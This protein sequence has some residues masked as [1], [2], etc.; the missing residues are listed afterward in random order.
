MA[1]EVPVITTSPVDCCIGNIPVLKS[2]IDF[3]VDFVTINL[4]KPLYCHAK[5]N[6]AT[7]VECIEY[8]SVFETF[9]LPVNGRYIF[10]QT[11]KTSID[12]SSISGYQDSY[13]HLS[14]DQCVKFI[15]IKLGLD[16]DFLTI[17]HRMEAICP[18]VKMIKPI[19]AVTRFLMIKNDLLNKKYG[20]K[21]YDIDAGDESSDTEV[22]EDEDSVNESNVNGTSTVM[23]TS[24]PSPMKKISTVNL[25]SGDGALDKTECH[26]IDEDLI[27]FGLIECYY[28]S[29]TF[30]DSEIVI[31]LLEVD[32]NVCDICLVCDTSSIESIRVAESNWPFWGITTNQVFAEQVITKFRGLIGE[33]SV[34]FGSFFSNSENKMILIKLHEPRQYPNATFKTLKLMPKKIQ[35]ILA[36]VESRKS[37][38]G[39]AIDLMVD[40]IF[41]GLIQSNLPMV[42]IDTKKIIINYR[43]VDS[44]HYLVIPLQS[45]TKL[46]H[47]HG[48]TSM[49]IYLDEPMNETIINS[50]IIT[51]N[52]RKKESFCKFKC[53]SLWPRRLKKMVRVIKIFKMY[54]HIQIVELPK[55]EHDKRYNILMKLDHI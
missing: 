24:S 9:D 50:P 7:D 16:L 29:I 22:E 2:V 52:P 36:N 31:N 20:D 4:D 32:G 37:L 26:Q 12:V 42:K 28:K 40:Q 30:T 49:F 55:S 35:S 46:E 13:N 21:I 11:N 10:I 3:G 33:D 39:L 38:V 8:C 53:V 54:S 44:K 34:G 15:T 5:L 25:A 6:L 17:V 27:Y 18:Q 23:D 51:Y 47:V 19:E 1:E 43:I 48:A 14:E 41:F 45:V